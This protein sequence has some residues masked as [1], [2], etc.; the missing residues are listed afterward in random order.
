V[1]EHT[2]VRRVGVTGTRGSPE[3]RFA[4][5]R[6]MTSLFPPRTKKNEIRRTTFTNGR[7]GRSSCPPRKSGAEKSGGKGFGFPRTAVGSGTEKDTCVFPTFVEK[8]EGGLKTQK[9]G[10]GKKRNSQGAMPLKQANAVSLG[11]SEKKCQTNPK[12]EH[13][14]NIRKKRTKR[15]RTSR[16]AGCPGNLFASQQLQEKKNLG[17]GKSRA[18]KIISPT[19]KGGRAEGQRPHQGSGARSGAQAVSSPCAEKEGRK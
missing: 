13:L 4:V 14:L 2:L 1:D 12:G 6:A 8:R 7:I 17:G 19:W 5:Y 11:A 18:K 3:D 16:K 10:G 15:G 9:P